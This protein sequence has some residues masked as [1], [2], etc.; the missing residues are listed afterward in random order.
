MA[1]EEEEFLKAEM[2]K[3][4]VVPTSYDIKYQDNRRTRILKSF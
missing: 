4:S 3:H 2:R 1:E